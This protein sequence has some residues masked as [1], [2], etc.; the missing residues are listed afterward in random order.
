MASGTYIPG[1]QKARPGIY[2]YLVALANDRVSRGTR[3]RVALPV[4]ADWGPETVQ[5]I[6]DERAIEST[7][8]KALAGNTVRLLKLAWKVGLKSLIVQRLLGASAAAATVTVQ[9][10][11]GTP[12]DVVTIPAKYKGARPNAD[13]G[14]WKMAVATNLGDNTKKDA[15]LYEGSTLLATWTFDGSPADLVAQINA[16][17]MGYLGAPTKLADGSGTVAN[18]AGVAFAGGDSGL[19]VTNQG[20]LDWLTEM[21]A[22]KAFDTLSLDGVSDTSLQDSVIT[23]LNRVRAEGLWV[24]AALG[25]DDDTDLSGGGTRALGINNRAVAYVLSGGYLPDEATVYSPADA[26]VWVA[27]KMAVTPLNRSFCGATTPFSAIGKRLTNTQITAAL[28]S[29][30]L[31]FDEKDGL[32][33][34]ED[35]RNTFNSPASTEDITWR[36]IQVS[37]ILDAINT[38]LTSVQAKF[39]GKVP[40]T[41]L[42]RTGIRASVL[43]YYRVLANDQVIQGDYDCTEDTQ[44]ASTGENAYLQHYF[45]PVSAIKRVYNSMTVGR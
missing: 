4:R 29:G 36:N 23:W 3:G 44:T 1:E 39:N 37:T 25:H 27:A 33:I 7:F 26:A 43:E 16:N 28:A 40:N 13:K 22:Y 35:D 6:E 32:V 24:Q 12:V 10:T 38:D 5:V 19:T 8:W 31:V 11:A 15:K 45:I 9:D 42:G 18:T 17:G 41:E 34:V 21:E 30:A 2:F 20:Y 14:A